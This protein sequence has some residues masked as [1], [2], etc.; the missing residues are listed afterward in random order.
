MPCGEYD[1]TFSSDSM[2]CGN[3]PIA[4]QPERDR[5]TLLFKPG[6][7]GDG[8]FV[9]TPVQTV[10]SDGSI[11]LTTKVGEAAGRKSYRGSG[12]L[13]STRSG[14]GN[15]LRVPYIRVNLLFSRGFWGIAWMSG[16]TVCCGLRPQRRLLSSP[17]DKWKNLRE[18]AGVQASWLAYKPMDGKL[19]P[20]TSS[21]Q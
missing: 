10:G 16:S 5:D 3:T 19:L 15:P 8:E 17:G 7:D 20:S 2:I 1:I 6:K 4:R 14:A 9:E 12:T 13:E 11:I 21:R 18:T